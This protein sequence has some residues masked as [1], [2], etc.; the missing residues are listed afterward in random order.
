MEFKKP[1]LL[2]V[3]QHN[4]ETE[5]QHHLG[6]EVNM[7]DIP[8]PEF[9]FYRIDVARSCRAG[10]KDEY[11]SIFSGGY[12]FSVPMKMD[13]LL[14]MIEKHTQDSDLIKN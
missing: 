11:C 8:T 4:D 13:K 6:M 1:L 7:A 9:A 10:K 5:Q 2:P 14:K 12:E 3:Y